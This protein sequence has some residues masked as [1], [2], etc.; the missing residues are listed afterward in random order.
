MKYSVGQVLF[1]ILKS[2]NRV[3]P[4]QVIEEITKKT[5]GG[6]EISYMVK[7]GSGDDP[8]TK[9]LITEVSGEIFDSA[10]KARGALTERATS[11]INRLVDV[12]V[13]KANEWYPNCFESSD[14]DPVALLK[15]Q[16]TTP[17]QPIPKQP[18]AK[19][20]NNPSPV[21]DLKAELA[22]EA[23]E[24]TIITLPDGRQAKVRSVKLPDGMS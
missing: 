23:E 5:L 9:M 3:Y 20:A 24:A 6:E 22:A 14:D 18:R 15:K 13:Q 2:E 11:V 10:S 4:M 17:T 21:E 1:V 16:P 12:A 19:R 7:A 8:K